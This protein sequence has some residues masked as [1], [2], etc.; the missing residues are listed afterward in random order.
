MHALYGCPDLAVDTSRQRYPVVVVTHPAL[1]TKTRGGVVHNVI[2]YEVFLTNL[3]WTAFT[4]AEMLVLYQY[5][6]AFANDLADEDAEWCLM[7]SL[8][9]FSSCSLIC[10]SYCSIFCCFYQPLLCAPLTSRVLAPCKCK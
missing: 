8:P 1:K 7:V 10:C 2:D 6:G 9:G 5:R 3:L 4:A